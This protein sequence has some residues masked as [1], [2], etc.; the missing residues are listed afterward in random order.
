MRRDGILK[1]SWRVFRARLN[2]LETPE[3]TDYT[4]PFQYK[5]PVGKKVKSRNEKRE[6]NG[7]E[8]ASESRN[9]F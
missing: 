6:N 7:R 4:T 3:L 2:H 1:I 8:Q 9:G 5:N